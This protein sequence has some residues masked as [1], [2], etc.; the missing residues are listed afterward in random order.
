MSCKSPMSYVIII[1]I[2]NNTIK[3]DHYYEENQ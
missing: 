3:G 2:L 1:S